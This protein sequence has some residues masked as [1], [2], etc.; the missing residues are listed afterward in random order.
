MRYVSPLAINACASESPCVDTLNFAGSFFIEH[1]VS[2]F[3]AGINFGC[4]ECSIPVKYEDPTA[5]DEA[6]RTFRQS[7]NYVRT[8]EDSPYQVPQSRQDY[9]IIMLPVAG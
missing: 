1:R 3:P 7:I 6:H 8:P 9:N 4:V 5:I 2:T